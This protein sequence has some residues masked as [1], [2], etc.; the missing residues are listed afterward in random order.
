MDDG[1]LRPRATSAV[2][3]AIPVAVAL[4]TCL[5]LAQFEFFSTHELLSPVIRLHEM[6]HVMTQNGRI[7]APWSPDLAFGHGL[8]FFIYYA[9][10]ATYVAEV[11]HLLGADLM[12]AVKISFALS[13]V[14]SA[15]AMAL[16]LS[17]LSKSYRFPASPATIALA[18]AAY[19]TAPYRMVDVYVRGSFAECWSFVWFP[20]IL[21]GCHMLAGERRRTGIVIGSLA[22]AALMLSHNISALYFTAV[23]CVYVLAVKEVRR[24]WVRAAI[25]IALGQA[26]SAFF[27]VPALANMSL[28]GTE[29]VTMWATAKDVASHAVHW[30]QFF[31]RRWEFGLSVPGPDDGMSFALGWHIIAAVVLLPAVAVNRRER[32]DTRRLASVVL[33]FV[34]LSVVAMTRIMPWNLV[35]HLFRYIQFPWRLLAFTT[36]FGSMAV[37]LGLHALLRWS[38]VG[39]DTR[40]RA[41]FHLGVLLLIL[42]LAGPIVN[43]VSFSPGKVD[44]EYILERLQVEESAGYIGTTA[45][46]EY[47]PATAA[48]RTLDPDWNEQ[49]YSESHVEVVDG[50]ATV[51]TWTNQ[52]A[53]YTVDV[54]CDT[55]ATIAFQSYYFPGWRYRRDGVTRD[56]EMKLGEEGFIHVTLPAGK[57]HLV[58]EYGSPPWGRA[59]QFVSGAALLGLLAWLFRCRLQRQ[60]R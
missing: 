30:P 57:H 17:H 8:P 49:H 5:P 58:F 11:P 44:R 43:A 41:V 25:M 32:P 7:L 47:V 29:P 26:L 54:Q 2:K 24:Q 18:S 34:L 60:P 1:S 50:Q 22:Y 10:L 42:A 51:D 55:D 46:S 48:P 9:P 28:V 38:E 40:L 13:L 37:F 15:A 21:L 27:W 4:L 56:D 45:R 6:H 12:Q 20:L 19:V 35:P 36:L 33:A 23:L 16:F 52:G 14:L 59:S 31:S 3:F 53:R 39:S